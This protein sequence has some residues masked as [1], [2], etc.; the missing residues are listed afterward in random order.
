MT[1]S[2]NWLKHQSINLSISQSK[3][4]YYNT[5]VTKHR[6]WAIGLIREAA[7]H[8]PEIL[9]N[10]FCRV[11]SDRILCICCD[12]QRFPWSLEV[13][14]QTSPARKFINTQPHQPSF[15]LLLCYW[16]TVNKLHNSAKCWHTTHQVLKHPN[17]LCLQIANFIA[18]RWKVAHRNSLQ[19]ILTSNWFRKQH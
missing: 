19:K 17:C 7:I 13:N 6:A 3:N 5:T 15:I 12:F 2:T 16:K 14:W 18:V 10:T 4:F 8:R 11:P 1:K 9:L